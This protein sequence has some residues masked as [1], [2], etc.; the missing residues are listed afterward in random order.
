MNTQTKT[1]GKQYMTV[2]HTHEWGQKRLAE[3]DKQ[4]EQTRYT[5][6]SPHLDRLAR[7]NAKHK[8]Y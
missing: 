6:I 2:S 8:K 3:A 5:N 1:K 4:T 7:H